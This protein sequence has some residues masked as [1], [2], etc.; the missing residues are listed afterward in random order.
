VALPAGG[1]SSAGFI[2]AYIPVFA[3]GDVLVPGLTVRPCYRLAEGGGEEGRDRGKH[4]YIYRCIPS[5]W[6]PWV[7]SSPLCG[8]PMGAP[9]PPP[10]GF[11]FPVAYVPRLASRSCS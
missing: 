1:G 6:A 8:S 11:L 9:P 5:V 2:Y 4:T 3:K 10:V 7:R